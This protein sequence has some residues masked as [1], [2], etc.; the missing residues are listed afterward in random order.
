MLNQKL[1][2]FI[3]VAAPV[4]TQE[5]TTKVLKTLF[6]LTHNGS[7]PLQG[8]SFKNE[9][10]ETMMKLVSAWAADAPG[11]IVCEDIQW[12]DPASIELLEHLFELSNR[13]PILFICTMRPDRNSPG[14]RIKSVADHDY[15]HLY[16]EIR[17]DSL[18]PEESRVLVSALLENNQLPERLFEEIYTKTAG[19]PFYT[20]EIVRE[21]MSNRSVIP[22]RTGPGWQPA[23]DYNQIRTTIPDTLQSMLAARIDRLDD[24]QK[25]TL[26]LAAVIGP[27]FQFQILMQVL[28][29]LNKSEKMNEAD[30]LGILGELQRRKMIVQVARQPDL[31][32]A[33]RQ[34][35]VHES[36]YRTIL[37]RERRLY[38]LKTGEAIESLFSEQLGEYTILLAH[39]FTEA[40]DRERSLTY[41]VKAADAAYRLYANSA[42]VTHYSRALMAAEYI[43]VDITQ[44]IH[45]YESRG[46]ALELD[47][48]LQEA[49]GNYE[50]MLQ[51]SKDLD[52]L[53]MELV[54][55]MSLFTLY[56]TPSSIFDFNHGTKL[57]EKALA[58]ARELEDKP[59]EAKI[60][61]NLLNLNRSA[62]RT[63]KALEYGE[64]SLE[65][66]RELELKELMAYCLNDLSHMYNR[67]GQY[68]KSKDAL[69]EA[70]SLW[71]ALD[72]LPMLANSL[73]T[74]SQVHHI[75]GNY[76]K[77]ISF[78][79]EASQ[80]SRSIENI[81][82][83]SYSQGVI[84][85]VYWHRGEVEK[86]LQ[87]M[88]ESVALAE[89][90]KFIIA[91]VYVGSNLAMFYA[92]LGDLG[93]GLE[94]AQEAMDL[95][96]KSTP[97]LIGPPAAERLARVHVRLG[98]L[99]K[100]GELVE[101]IFA[102]DQ[103]V[104]LNQP[105]LPSLAECELAF[106]RG[107]L[108]KARQRLEERLAGLEGYSMFYNIP[109]TGH[110]LSQVY[111]TRKEKDKAVEILRKSLETSRS[112]KAMWQTWQLLALLAD[113]VPQEEAV[114][115]RE[116]AR[117]IVAIIAE[118]ISDPGLK[119]TML[120]RAEIVSA[121]A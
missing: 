7:T 69:E 20:E 120:D 110:L 14:W 72:N 114:L 12:S 3:A 32:Y 45:L 74:T 31:A 108:T 10:F 54:A 33:F 53:E 44:L 75:I 117:E 30:L 42:A 29:S 25:H 106:S 41:N 60:L 23:P 27:S 115:C 40:E 103:P 81:W 36:A 19:N 43:D 84:G 93:R 113:L 55:L 107:D 78:S 38:H 89:K 50:A 46:R 90:S 85:P 15:P 48:R 9:L 24:R 94:K 26:Q 37:R 58:I 62:G 17:L 99:D 98:N 49:I 64:R 109:E 82:G 77:A 18:S 116:E 121:L 1:V 5:Q 4:E 73:S 2:N 79:E 97:K 21:M 71:R 96:A 59:A 39:H 104:D 91:Q 87:M 68:Q 22:D 80:I 105:D 70:V 52:S 13:L 88:E 76:D 66:S 11:V 119:K 101:K 56:A 65:I 86:A 112:M 47:S 111:T 61:W 92:E 8:E 34:T 28:N 63:L 6:G 95:A 102:S 51:K 100:A 57:S 35:L 83:I 16:T 118:N 67:L